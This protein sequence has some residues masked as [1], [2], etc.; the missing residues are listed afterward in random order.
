MEK[1]REPALELLS[2][3]FSQL[4]QLAASITERIFMRF[5]SVRPVIMEIITGVLVAER[6]HAR[7]ILE[8]IIDAEQNYFFTNDAGYKENRSS[9]V[10]I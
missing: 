10:A 8:A 5:P 4:E 1:L 2:D 6:D 3:V 7:E 9:I